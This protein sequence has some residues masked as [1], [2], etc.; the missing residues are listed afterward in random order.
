MQGWPRSCP[1]LLGR[2][3]SVSASHRLNW[4]PQTSWDEQLTKLVVF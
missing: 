1:Y 2:S 4:A 3:L